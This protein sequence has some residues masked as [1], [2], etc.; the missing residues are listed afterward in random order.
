MNRIYA[1]LAALA[2]CVVVPPA[3]TQTLIESSSETRLQ[4]DLKVPDAALK[5]FFPEGFT[6]NPAAQG[7]AK[8]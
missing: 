1:T 8:D 7:P 5:S 4:L 2:L 3:R 6:S